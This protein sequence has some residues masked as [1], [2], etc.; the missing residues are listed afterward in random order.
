MFSFHKKKH[1][2][3]SQIT[4]NLKTDQCINKEDFKSVFASIRRSENG[5]VFS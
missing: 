2:I 3:K 5:P 1:F 4:L